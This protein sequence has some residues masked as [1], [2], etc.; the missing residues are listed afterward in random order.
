MVEEKLHGV[1]TQILELLDTAGQANLE[2]LDSFHCGKTG[3]AVQLLHDLRA[4][5]HSVASTGVAAQLEHSG[6]EEMLENAEDTLDDIERAIQ[7]GNF[8]RAA[9]KMEFQ[10]FPFLRQLKEGFYFWGAVYPDQDKLHAYYRSAFAEHIQNFYIQPNQP[11]PFQLSIVVPA[12]N[13]LDTTKRCIEQ[14]LK[15]T[16]FEKLH[17]E[18]ILI[19]H[20][21]TDGTLEYFEG[22]GIGKVIRFKRNA[23]MNMF[24]TM[25]QVCQGEYLAYVSNDVLVTRNWA[26]I[27]LKSFAADSN[28]IAA[29]PATPNVANLQMLDSPTN[30]SNGFIAWANEQNR[31]DPSRWDDRVRLMPPVGMYRT[32]AV[33]KIG[34]ADPY[35]YTMEFWDDDFSLRARRAGY[36]Q[37]ICHDVAC[38]HYG[39]VTGKEAQKKDN[40][41]THGRE[42]FLRKNGIDAWGNGFCYDYQ[43]V[44]LFKQL[45]GDKKDFKILGLD[46]GVGDTPLQIKNEL[47]HLHRG[48]E[49]YQL[50][51]QRKYLADI[52]PHSKQAYFVSE[53]AEGLDTVLG[54]ELFDMAYLGREIGA[55]ENLRELLEGISRKLTSGGWFVCSCDNPYHALTLHAL[56]Q[57]TLPDGAA[58]CVLTNPE[59]IKAE[60][61][62]YFSQVQVIS[63]ANPINGIKEFAGAHWGK[64]GR[65]PQIVDRL[66][67][68][69][70][71]FACKV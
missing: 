4:V 29:V 50:S 41:L 3:E 8:E 38:Y 65:L 34:F 49:L 58:R 10:L 54:A 35:F 48:C 2:L 27:L 21:S 63:V 24:I 42:L 68:S 32:S 16:D 56:L 70:Y 45:F 5:I 23:R 52:E 40:T 43:A 69:K 39:S 37:V 17:A 25:F 60:A 22:L 46:C 47:R 67:I 6:M 57:F 20:G 59:Q 26:E 44:H 64:S 1:L 62:Q 61:E 53:L 13:H 33:N 30:D 66:G 18:L 19:D 12:Y 14:L 31:S 71:Y 9:M 36:R 7:A 28:I 11:S 15:E 55:Y 51:S